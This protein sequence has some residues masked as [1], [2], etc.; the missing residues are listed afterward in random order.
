MKEVLAYRKY[1]D[2]NN[3]FFA[4]QLT[5]DFSLDEIV[6]HP[7]ISNKKE[8]SFLMYIGIC[9]KESLHTSVPIIAMT[10]V[11]VDY[12]NESE[13]KYLMD[14]FKDKFYKYSY[15]MYTTFSYTRQVPKFRV[16]FP[17]KDI[18]SVIVYKDNI[19]TN[20]L[21]ELFKVGDEYPDASCFR[22]TQGQS[23][24]IAKSKYNYKYKINKGKKLKLKSYTE[25]LNNVVT[26]NFKSYKESVS[27][28]SDVLRNGNEYVSSTS[29]KIRIVGEDEIHSNEENLERM[30]KPNILKRK[31]IIKEF[32]E[33]KENV[34]ITKKIKKKAT[35]YRFN[36]KHSLMLY[37]IPLIKS[38]K[39]TKVEL[40]EIWETNFNEKLSDNK[41][42]TKKCNKFFERSYAK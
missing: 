18:L 29:R 6:K 17:L 19:Y 7:I 16:I 25:V 27:I 42:W 11:I 33:E 23:Y 13:D 40:E 12:D 28:I 31:Y 15:Y 14:K 30:R 21:M 24:P 20:Y 38:G 35:D 1:F 4:K 10:H 22:L 41:K 37:C 8:D 32:E 34:R 3:N 2:D 36:N 26:N 39:M 9:T 5:E